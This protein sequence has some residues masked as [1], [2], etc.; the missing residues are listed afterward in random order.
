ME[1]V[2][3]DEKG[4]YQLDNSSGDAWAGP[5]VRAVQGHSI[6]LE[7]PLHDPIKAPHEVPLALHATSHDSWRRIRTCGE[8][9][10]MSRTHIHFASQ[11][12]HLRGN[13]WA[14]VLLKVDL[15]RAVEDGIGFCRAANGVVLSEGPIPL[16]YLSRVRFGQLPRE[17]QEQAPNRHVAEREPSGDTLGGC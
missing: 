14:C 4:R 7:N 13:D 17:W 6:A 16:R 8:L 10:R 3:T 9:R 15:K 1:I 2:R 5:R 12:K 11:P